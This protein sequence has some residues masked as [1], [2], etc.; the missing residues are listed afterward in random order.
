[1]SLIKQC[2]IANVL[3][4]WLEITSLVRNYVI[5]KKLRHW[6]E[7]TSRA[8]NDYGDRLALAYCVNRYPNPFF[9]QFFSKRN[10]VID[11]D[12]FALAEMIQWIWRSAIRN[13]KPITIYIPSERMRVLFMKWLNDEEVSF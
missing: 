1:M 5:G 13:Y 12:K 8:T 6:L 9:E 7:I 4:H 3:R 11:Q 2:A 10:V